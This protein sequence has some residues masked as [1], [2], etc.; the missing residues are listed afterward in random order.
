M[1]YAESKMQDQIELDGHQRGTMAAKP[2]PRKKCCDG[3]LHGRSAGRPSTAATGDALMAATE[4]S[5]DESGH[6]DRLAD[7]SR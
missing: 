6:L 2:I 4:S 1:G 7:G 5:C 3:A